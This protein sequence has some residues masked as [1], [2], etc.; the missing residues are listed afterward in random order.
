[1]DKEIKLIGNGTYGCIFHPGIHCNKKNNISNS[2][3]VTK[4]QMNGIE[5][6]NEID[7]GKM[8][9]TVPNYSNRF[10]PIVESCNLNISSVKESTIEKCD[11]GV[12]AQNANEFVSSRINYVGSNTLYSYFYK[13]LKKDV[14]HKIK[15]RSGAVIKTNI[16]KNFIRYIVKII[17]THIYLLES[18]QLFQSKNLTHFD[19][20]ENNII[21]DEK[22]K[23]PIIIDYGISINWNAL[24]TQKN[25]TEKFSFNHFETY[26][27]WCIES[28]LFM[29]ACDRI[30]K[31]KEPAFFSKK[32]ELSDLSQMKNTLRSFIIGD[33]SKHNRFLDMNKEEI[34]K[35]E[36]KSK[37]YINSFKDKS[38]NDIWTSLM[39]S[40]HNWDNYSMAH[41]FYYFFFK[42]DLLGEDTNINIIKKYTILLKEL[43]M[44]EPCKRSSLQET[45]SKLKNIIKHIN[46]E[47]T[48][49]V[50][51]NINK[52][53]ENHGY[54]NATMKR[55]DAVKLEELQ[56]EK[57]R[58]AN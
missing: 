36:T 25:Y 11:L 57:I 10:A 23:V 19:L 17:E 31:A 3:F 46:K 43:M 40:R 45:I 41:I 22:N 51:K 55:I 50:A 44:N 15:V 38:W 39:N 53:A 35:F 42:F 7:I 29:H 16:K 26:P 34:A 18:L 32:I 2:S 27:Y 8:I 21:Y 24:K 13:L 47:E 54:L 1:M 5:L 4:V 6:K 28:V 52:K 56:E 20:K 49:R 12:N 14:E 37:H 48:M 33:D 58:S 9:K 30:H